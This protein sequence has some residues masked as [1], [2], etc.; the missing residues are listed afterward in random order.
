MAFHELEKFKNATCIIKNKDEKISY[1][2]LGMISDYMVSELPPKSI[3]LLYFYPKIECIAAYLGALRNNHV[4]I[5]IDPFL[6]EVL[7]TKIIEKF[8]LNF[9]YDGKKWIDNKILNVNKILLHKDLRIL[10]STSGSTG[11]PK[12]IRISKQ[13][14]DS[15]AK[16]IVEY[17]RLSSSD[18]AISSLPLYYSYGLSVLN[19][20]LEIGASFCLTKLGVTDKDFW[21]IFKSNK[22]TGLAGVPATWRILRKLFFERMHLPSLRLL[23]QAGGKLNKEEIK[24]LSKVG[25]QRK[26]KV[27]IM[28]GQTEA[29][30]RIAYLDPSMIEIK[31]GSIGKSIPGGKLYL[32]N[33]ENKIIEEPNLEG[34]LVYKGNNVMMGY[35]YEKLDLSKDKDTYELKTGDL[36]FRDNENYY[37]ITGRKSR[38]IKIFGMRFSLDDAEEYFH[39]KGFEAA[40]VG[41]DDNLII[42]LKKRNAISKDSLVLSFSEFYKIHHSAINIFE[43]IDIPKNSSSKIDYK[44]LEEKYI[45]N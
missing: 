3:F 7:K 8:N 36:A 42:I 35:A 20:H 9:I 11:S 19:T 41:K 26:Y 16:S 30:A 4:A 34:E 45:N 2:E 5:L 12:L 22:V 37:W 32:K 23:T 10:L 14:L 21:N 29:T 28:Y 33:S 17:M 6:N 18:I 1:E 39:N 25:D 44:K 15:N 27:F 13:N 38:F 40:V 24:W 31:C 43:I